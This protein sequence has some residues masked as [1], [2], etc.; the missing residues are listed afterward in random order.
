MMPG[1]SPAMQAIGRYE[2]LGHLASGGMAE[3]LLA[4]LVGPSGFQRPVV[5]KR[6]LS[7]L[8]RQPAFVEMFV[9]EARVAAGIR[10]P[11][12]V[13]V[14]ELGRDG[15]E[16][17]LVM[18]YLEGE[19]VGGLLRRLSATGWQLEPTLAAHVIAEAC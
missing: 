16:L 15:D 14:Q 12:V 10:H 7:H 1:G 11:N 9:D 8:A 18:E 19:S 17:F 2:I 6:I 4:R 5:I 3:V 13:Q